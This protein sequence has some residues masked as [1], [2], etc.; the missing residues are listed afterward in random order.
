MI[1]TKSLFASLLLAAAPAVHAYEP[2]VWD[3]TVGGAA[4][5]V[6]T[7][8]Q[9]KA[10]V[11][12]ILSFHFQFNNHTVTQSSFD[13]PCTP[14]YG[15]FDSGFMPVDVN[16]TVFPVYNVTV[17]T[18]APIWIH[19]EQSTHCEKGMV[20]AANAPDSGNTFD[21]FL[22]KALATPVDTTGASLTAS[23]S[24]SVTWGDA[25]ATTSATATW[26]DAYSAA[27][28]TAE[29]NYKRNAA[30]EEVKRGWS[31]VMVKREAY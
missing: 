30:E 20:F 19:C 12:D 17:D 18:T 2:K 9:V 25:Y 29:A 21:A 15:G 11:G 28:S 3:I 8:N 1:S 7:P 27:T 14:L 23:A 13:S 31:R 4:G 22:A 16:A 6:Y 10:N 26:G 24:P 5:L